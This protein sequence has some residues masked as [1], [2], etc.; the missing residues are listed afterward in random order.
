M[1]VVKHFSKDLYPSIQDAVLEILDEHI[2]SEFG[3]ATNRTP[4]YGS[5]ALDEVL[6]FLAFNN[7]RHQYMKLPAPAG[8]DCDELIS[9]VWNY[10]GEIGH[11]VWYS[12]GATKH[13][14]RVSITVVAETMEEI[15]DWVSTVEAVDIKDWAIDI[16]DWSVEEL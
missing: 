13:A 6:G 2:V 8:A 3:G 11:E 15:E 5:K 14:Y 16:K 4:I 10:P 9:V 1:S 7:I 12:Q